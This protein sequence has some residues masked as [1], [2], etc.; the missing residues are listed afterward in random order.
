MR[1][2]AKVEELEKSNFPQWQCI[3]FFELV[4]NLSN[5]YISALSKG[6]KSGKSLLE[7]NIVIVI[8]LGTLLTSANLIRTTISRLMK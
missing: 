7:K 8:V 1:R 3:V 6:I 5:Q 2:G 4:L